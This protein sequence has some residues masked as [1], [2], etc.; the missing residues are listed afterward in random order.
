M[1]AAV[2]PDD[3]PTGSL[4]SRIQATAD[5]QKVA[6]RE[7]KKQELLLNSQ[8]TL[9]VEAVRGVP[10]ELLRTALFSA[11]NRKTPRR[12]LRSANL[13]VIGDGEIIFTG[14]ELRQDDE[15]VWLQLMHLA[16]E[17]GL[18]SKFEFTPH[19]F[20][21]SI[22]WPT[23]G[24][25]YDRLDECMIRLQATSLRIRSKRLGDAISMSMLPVF[26]SN[27]KR[28]SEDFARPWIAGLHSDLVLLFSDF[29]YTR[30]DWQRR[31]ELPEGLA[32]W[33]HAYYAS[34]RDPFPV[35]V[36]TLWLGSG[37]ADD[38]DVTPPQD[39]APEARKDR[40]QRQRNFVK[41]LKVALESLCK[42]GFLVSF[43]IQKG[44]VSVK[45]APVQF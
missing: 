1:T 33:L 42:I 9:W 36:E 28:A 38:A 43:E 17:N 14:Q 19:S 37:L 22:G 3:K 35:R 30:I 34:H 24:Q 23:T 4:A 5:R 40:L 8:L 41:T 26:T 18:A 15:T 32:T 27:R 25:S 10:N 6:N 16:R 2:D 44:L 12:N 29:Q 45:R 21:K 11:R 39:E 20:C 31:L 7:K 13:A